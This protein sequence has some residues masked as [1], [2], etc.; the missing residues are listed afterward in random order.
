MLKKRWKK[1]IRTKH[2]YIQLNFDLSLLPLKLKFPTIYPPISF[3]LKTKA[4]KNWLGKYNI[5]DV[6]GGY[7]CTEEKYNFNLFKLN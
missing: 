2:A 7:F 6:N 4:R 1:Y 3:Y 5:L